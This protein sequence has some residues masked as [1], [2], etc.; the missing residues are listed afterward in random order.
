M[1]YKKKKLN[2]IQRIAERKTQREHRLRGKGLYL[3]KNNTPGT[4]LLP[5]PAANGKTRVE[6]NGEFEGDDY[7]MFL[8]KTAPNSLRLVRV[9]TSPPERQQT[10]LSE[11][12]KNE[13]KLILDQPPTVTDKGVVEHVTDQEEQD[14]NIQEGKPQE[15]QNE[16]LLN[17]DPLDGVTIL[18]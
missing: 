18:G 10:M 2:K 9:L 15:D 5:K 13:E 16:V 7:F 8:V 11:D 3:Y 6:V 12:V 4:L 1:R 17:D 14:E